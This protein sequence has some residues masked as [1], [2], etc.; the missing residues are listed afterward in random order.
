M[1]KDLHNKLLE[2]SV[3]IKE[4]SIVTSWIG[5]I[6]LSI[7]VFDW[8]ESLIF[9]ILNMLNFLFIYWESSSANRL[10]LWQTQA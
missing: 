9:E 10:V 6:A 2:N 1:I 5:N 8:F 4:L 7:L 3:G